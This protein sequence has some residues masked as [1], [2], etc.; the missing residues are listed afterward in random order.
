MIE[1]IRVICTYGCKKNCSFCYQKKKT[2]KLLHPRKFKKIL[3]NIDF[4]PS[5]FTFQGGE[6]SENPDHLF[7]LLK[8]ADEKF[9]QVFRKSVTTNGNGSSWFY[10][11]LKLY[12]ATH[13]TFSLNNMFSLDLMNRIKHLSKSG[14]YTVRV[15][16]YL[17]KECPGKIRDIFNFCY[18]H[19]LQLTLCGDLIKEAKDS[20]KW[21]YKNLNLED[22]R[23]FIHKHQAIF[24]S[25]KREYKFWLYKHLDNYDYN[26]LIV[27]PNGETTLCFNDVIEGRGC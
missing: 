10:D 7:S 11:H 26:N 1:G 5:Y 20:A 4:F 2:N 18:E 9:P 16:C 3:N 6:V 27:L 24:I 21:L 12:G 17:D 25:E 8:I 23:V 22:Y 13:L 14:F 15:N 19:D